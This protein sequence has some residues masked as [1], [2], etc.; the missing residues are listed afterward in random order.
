MGGIDPRDRR[1]LRIDPAD[2]EQPHLLNNLTAVA[3]FVGLVLGII[4]VFGSKKALAAVGA[5]LCV[6][7]IVF[8]VIA[9]EIMVEE[10]NKTIN[11]A[12]SGDGTP[13][14][15]RSAEPAQQGASG[16]VR[17]E[18]TG[19][20][21]TNSISF[22]VDGSSSQDTSPT[23]PWSQEQPTQDGFHFYSLTAQNGGDDGEIEYRLTVNGA[24]I[25][26]QTSTGPYSFVSC[27]G[28]SGL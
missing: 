26:E 21:K 6:L 19:S 13:P 27:T 12:D 3:A 20:G 14:K 8:T 16:T 9:Q 28:N 24:V 10:L 11:G 17:Y 4:A 5:S 2:F 23:L 22:G 18:V 1:D 15:S 25:A 7:A